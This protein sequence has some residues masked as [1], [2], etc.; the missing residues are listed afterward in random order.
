MDEVLVGDELSTEIEPFNP[1]ASEF[2]PRAI[3]SVLLALELKPKD[4]CVKVSFLPGSRRL[5]WTCHA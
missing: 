3:A 2:T 4:I 5:N 1:D